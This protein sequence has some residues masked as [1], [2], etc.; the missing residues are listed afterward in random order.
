MISPFI[1]KS[2]IHEEVLKSMYNHVADIIESHLD[3]SEHLGDEDIKDIIEYFNSNLL[4]KNI[5][6]VFFD[7]KSVDEIIDGLYDLIVSEYEE[8]IGDIPE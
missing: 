7:D 8:K 3:E 1:K 4:R 5:D 6:E 2:Q